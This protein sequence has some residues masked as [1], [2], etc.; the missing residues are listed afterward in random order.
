LQAVEDPG[1]PF[2]LGVQWH[3]EFLLYARRQRTL[4]EALVRAA[5][6]APS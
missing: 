2:L 4:F 1:R 5:G 6:D 3:P